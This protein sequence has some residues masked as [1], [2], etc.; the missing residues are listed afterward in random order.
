MFFNLLNIARLLSIFLLL[1][2]PDKKGFF[3]ILNCCYIKQASRIW[4]ESGC[5]T[6]VA[7]VTHAEILNMDEGYIV[8]QIETSLF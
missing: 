2:R 7:V 4:K 1:H 8:F 3:K 6:L 5:L